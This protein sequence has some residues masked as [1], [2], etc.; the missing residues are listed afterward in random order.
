MKLTV[1]NFGPIKEAENVNVSPLTIFVGPSNTGKS[2]LAILIYSIIKT[3]GYE[4]TIGNL[5]TMPGMEESALFKEMITEVSDLNE[6]PQA[7]QERGDLIIDA[8]FLSWARNITDTL[9]NQIIY[10]FGEEGKKMTEGLSINITGP[11]SGLVLDLSSPDNSKLTNQK[12]QQ[13][14]AS[15]INPLVENLSREIGEY[16]NAGFDEFDDNDLDD[17]PDIPYRLLREYSRDSCQQFISSLFEEPYP[18]PFNQ[19]HYLPA[20][21]GGIMQIHRT[22]VSALI[23]RTPMAGLSDRFSSIPP[24]TGV[25]SDFMTK[26]I[27]VPSAGRHP[28]FRSSRL[29][30]RPCD[31]DSAKKWIEKIQ[32]IGSEMEHRIMDGEIKVQ[33]SETRYPDFRYV[34]QKDNEGHDLPLMSVSSMVSE[35]A[36]VSLFIRHHVRY[37]DLLILEEPEAHLHP[38]AQREMSDILVQLVNAGIYVLIT[39]HSDT[40]LEQVGNCIHAAD[41][42]KSGTTKLDKDK[43]SAYLFDRPAE[44]T[45]GNTT[46]K[47]IP[48]DTETGLLTR[49]HLD[50]SSALYN[51]TIN[52]MEQRDNAGS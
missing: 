34:F 21:R 8:C 10:C 39:T 36:P 2:Y 43:C 47:K 15:V 22:L 26:L 16:V 6:L 3:L 41:I 46:V 51:E 30:G 25:L 27:N 4:S 7:I 13:I 45:R 37:G 52:L 50:V 40:I 29:S 12:K 18:S 48:F 38:A 28:G 35:L 1:K 24:F 14:V 11:E 44:R 20:I 33:L 31:K 42:P 49:D 17:L 5:K 32:K 9:K 19:S 23:E